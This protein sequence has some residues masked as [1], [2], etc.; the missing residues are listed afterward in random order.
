MIQSL[1][2]A[3][4]LPPSQ[5][6]SYSLILLGYGF[7]YYP[8]ETVTDWYSES[9]R[10]LSQQGDKTGIALAQHA[11]GEYQYGSSAVQAQKTF[12]EALNTFTRLGNRWGMALCNLSLANVAN[13]VGAYPEAS[14]LAQSALEIYTDLGDP[15][16]QM[17]LNILL[18]Q[19]F[20]AQGS[21]PEARACLQ[22]ALTF[23]RHMGNRF[24]MGTNLDC[25]AYIETLEGHA[26]QAEEISRE[27]LATYRQINHVYG[28]GMA[29]TNLADA[30]LLRMDLEAARQHYLEALSILKDENV[31]WGMAKCLKKLGTIHLLEN[32]L[33]E[34]GEKLRQAL[35]ISVAV[36]RVSD[37]LE[38]LELLAEYYLLLGETEHAF[39]ILICLQGNPALTA[40]IRRR[41]ESL[42]ARLTELLGPQTVKELRRPGC[43]RTL[44]EWIAAEQSPVV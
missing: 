32:Q 44:E 24:F 37:A 26:G 28:I 43:N 34:A 7:G 38:I 11:Y 4:A 39:S 15:W 8:D 35:A 27:A 17:E 41:C 10:V 23:A 13:W 29:L 22:E 19:Y 16:R 12:E 5:A 30:M 21:Y 42:E 1:E 6:K 20:T 36:D 33:P 25:L 3:S 2:L 31:P 40:D 14:R 9:L 18:G